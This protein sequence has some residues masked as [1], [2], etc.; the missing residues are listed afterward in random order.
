MIEYQERQHS[1]SVPIFDKRM[2]V[3]GVARGVQ[4]ALYDQRR[5]DVLPIHGIQLIEFNY[6]DFA[7]GSGK[8][9]KRIVSEDAKIIRSK[10]RSY[11]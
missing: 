8:R 6:S 7:F 11:L 4:R 10:I 3:S 1:E 2:T 9:L 5:R